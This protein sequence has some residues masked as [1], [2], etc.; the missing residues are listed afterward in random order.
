MN[1]MHDR[2]KEHFPTILLTLLSIVQALALELLWSHIIEQGALYEWSF[3]ALLSW[4]QILATLIG[5]VLI[6]VVYA[7]NVM[8]FSWVPSIS[9]T[10]VPFVVG[11]L[12]FSLVALLGVSTIGWWMIVMALIFAIMNWIAHSTMRRA[13]Y[14][15]D[16]E[17]FFRGRE[18]AQWSDFYAEALIIGLL[19][20]IG[21][22]I[23]WSG[24]ESVFAMLAVTATLCLLIW[25]YLQNAGFWER[26]VGENPES[27]PN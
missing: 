6:W 23:Q 9:D 17:A 4:V 24:D 14:D 21:A 13:R 15:S 19:A 25:Q 18:P 8:R 11:L 26:S 7:S 22:G 20:V 2:A 27:A 12:E 16:N 3:A 1:S 5:I 10:V